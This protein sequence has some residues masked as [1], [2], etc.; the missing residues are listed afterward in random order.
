VIEGSGPA[1]AYKWHGVE[2]RTVY[3]AMPS[4]ATWDATSSYPT[5]DGRFDDGVTPNLYVARSA[6]G[7]L[8]EYLRHHPELLSFLEDDELIVSMYEFEVSSPKC[9]DIREDVDATNAGVEPHRLRSSDKDSNVRY[10]ECRELLARVKVEASGIKYP[11]A[12][13]PRVDQWNLVLLG[14]ETDYNPS[15]AREATLPVVHESDVVRL[16]K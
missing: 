6:F 3:R 8:C 14:D 15:I 13:T 7:A 4:D 16:E 12:A 2:N 5:K 11:T 9:L 1:H 10:A